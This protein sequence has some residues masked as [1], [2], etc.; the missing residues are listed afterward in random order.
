MFATLEVEFVGTAN[1]RNFYS[2][3]LRMTPMAIPDC[4]DP[5][6]PEC[7]RGFIDGTMMDFGQVAMEQSLFA[8]F[9]SIGAAVQ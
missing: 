1:R 7:M 2:D 5:V 4:G 6:D 9:S 8:G 3:S